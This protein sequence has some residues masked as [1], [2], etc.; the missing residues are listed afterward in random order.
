MFFKN[1]K[2]EIL[3]QLDILKSFAKGEINKIQLTNN[4]SDEILQSIIELA[5]IIQEKQTEELGVYGEIMLVSEKLADG[6]TD[7]RI[8]A[9]SSN[10]KLNY[11]AKT[12]NNM[13]EKLDASLTEIDKILNQYAKQNFLPRANENLFE[14]GK[15]KYLPVGINKLRD[16]MTENLTVTHRSSIVLEKE[17]KNTLI[18]MDNLTQNTASGL[19]YIN[20][21]NDLLDD[22]T[23]S[24]SNGM[25]ISKKMSE[26]GKIVK[27][28]ID[29]GMNFAN[30]TVN[31]MDNIN[32]STNA[33]NE[34]I[35]VIDQ[36]A[37]QTNILSLNAAVEAATAGEAGKGFAVVAGE[38]RNLASR[39]AQAAQQIKELV[40]KASNEAHEGK[41]IADSMIDG[42]SL[43]SENS[44]KT[45]ELISNMGEQSTLQQ[46]TILKIQE[47]INNIL[48][49]TNLSNETS[50]VVKLLSN[51]MKEMATSNANAIKVVQFDG[52]DETIRKENDNK[53]YNGAE[54]RKN[55]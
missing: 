22:I 3:T 15:L 49:L 17:S 13:A 34:A 9:I 39:S 38:V 32:E 14:A 45:L 12:L 18:H 27:Q 30:N 47:K 41:K 23:S 7:D 19:E 48:N 16:Y 4:N 46:N 44:D 2:A 33:V 10:P 26:N 24:I 37:F 29:S 8:T 31:A 43:L 11:I 21:T 55:L 36:I 1:N 28:S 53:R 5:N 50:Q 52:K 25:D 40:E 35:T 51:D 54:K 20:Q 6:L 42:Y